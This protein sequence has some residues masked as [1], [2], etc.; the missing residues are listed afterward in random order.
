MA[1][2]WTRALG[3]GASV[4]IAAAT[5]LVTNIV[6]EKPLWGWCI[7][8]GALIII[9]VAVQVWLSLG[10]SSAM[11]VNATGAGSVAI[12]GSAKGAVRT[13]VSGSAQDPSTAKAEQGILAHGP[14]SVAIGGDAG[15]VETDVVNRS[16]H[17]A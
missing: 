7:G 3:A 4:V 6:T 11:Q 17:D 8:L 2:R 10:Q 14:G 12:A 16:S 13:H 15:T 1:S 5:G 9:G